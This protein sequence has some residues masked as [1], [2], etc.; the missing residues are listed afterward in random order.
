MNDALIEA[1]WINQRDV[2]K[3]ASDYVPQLSRLPEKQTLGHQIH[4]MKNKGE[5]ID[6]T[7]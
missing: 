7:L 3:W 4:H 5:Y 1:V 6:D 2:E